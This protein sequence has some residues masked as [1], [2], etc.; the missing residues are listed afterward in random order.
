[1]PALR[2]CGRKTMIAGDELRI[3]S[4]LIGFG[5]FIQSG[6]AIGL[7]FLTIKQQVYDVELRPMLEGCDFSPDFEM[8]AQNQRLFVVGYVTIALAM[9]LVSLS[10]LLPMHIL[11]GR[12]T[13]TDTAPRRL[14]PMLC[15]ISISLESCLRVAALTFGIFAISLAYEF[16]G[17]TLTEEEFA[18]DWNDACSLQKTNRVILIISIVFHGIDATLSLFTL[19]YL[20]C[21]RVVNF[22]V[23]S[24]SCWNTFFNVCMACSSALTCCFFGGTKAIGGD[25][26]DI[27]ILLANFFNDDD[28]LDI[29][30][31]DVAAGLIMVRRE[32]KVEVI[33]RRSDL[34]FSRR[35][36]RLSAM[37]SPD[38]N[39]SLPTDRASISSVPSFRTLQTTDR[40]SIMST[41]NRSVTGDST[42]SVVTPGDKHHISSL[43][44][45]GNNNRRMSMGIR[46]VLMEDSNPDRHAVA[47]GAWFYKYAAASYGWVAVMLL[48]PVSG[49]LKM[50]Y[51]VFRYT[52]FCR[53]SE[54]KKY[55]NDIW[56]Q[57]RR[58]AI[59]TVLDH[60]YEQDVVYATFE[61]SVTKTP[62]FIAM[63]HA[64]KTVVLSIRGTMSLESLL[65]DISLTPESL[66]QV[67][68]EC[69]F[70]GSDH[71]T[72]RGMLACAKWIYADLKEHG[73]LDELV[74]PSGSHKEYSLRIVGHS[75]GAGVAS[76]LSLMLRS[77]YPN[78]R[79]LAFG[80][81]GC[82]FDAQLAEE[83]STWT[84][85]YVVDCDFVSRLSKESVE[86]LRNDVLEMIARIKVPKHRVF[87]LRR[88]KKAKHNEETLSKSNDDILF[89]AHEVET[90]NFRKQLEEFY[91]FQQSLKEM[92][93]ANYI[94][95]YIPG[96]ILHLHGVGKETGNE[97][98]SPRE[99]F[100]ATN[101]GMISSDS[102]DGRYTA[103]W[104]KRKDFERIV[105][106]SHLLWDH[107]P[108]F[109]L[110][111]FREV[112]TRFGLEEPFF[113]ERLEIDE[114]TGFEE[115]TDFDEEDDD[116][117]DD[118]F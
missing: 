102:N 54:S 116:D 19:I 79:C 21:C 22:G 47:E 37:S 107:H 31:S 33:R 12:G 46:E 50:I 23:N 2:L 86:A 83:S 8:F 36:L 4:L 93:A 1:M 52:T 99:E 95:L 104:A 32:N 85:S 108:G 110:D 24:D 87:E 98:L 111:S 15:H 76:I 57:L 35:Q 3:Y 84:T 44:S 49:T 34:N 48:K 114:E 63:D 25:F 30:P 97:N 92:D 28:I 7:T 90:S 91:A 70:D 94:P 6:L 66:E 67:G 109:G 61:H 103:R 55:V 13:P 40:R 88:L 18:T 58:L 89:G 60:L 73:F 106:S 14:M 62:Y 45:A 115:V 10:T 78:L 68:K 113:V 82:V 53:N 43:T 42:P 38:S 74:G 77:E 117:D 39:R 41:S 72:H 59:R 80:A 100:A 26:T 9:P 11:S 105:L 69:G 75:L 65:A 112:A 56:L 16:C 5:R 81:P 29:T 118:D 64:W 71:Y 51:Y 17:C 96:K 101:G 20:I 27:S